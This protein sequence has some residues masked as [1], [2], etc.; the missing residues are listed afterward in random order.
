MSVELKK[1]REQIDEIDNDIV[2]LFTKRFNIVKKIG[3]EKEK[4]G[5]KVPNKKREEE[6]LKKIENKKNKYEEEIKSLYKEFFK[7]SKKI[8]KWDDNEKDFNN[9]WREP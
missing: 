9:K 4:L 3:K 8:Q 6:I 7:Q 5:L 1:L 2:K